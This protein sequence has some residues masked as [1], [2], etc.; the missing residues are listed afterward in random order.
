[1]I[2]ALESLQ[3]ELGFAFTVIDVDADPALVARWDEAVPV[4]ATAGGTEICRHVL[5]RRRLE[6][7]LCARPSNGPNLLR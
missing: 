5:D 1:M 4:L 7:A 3:P 6:S 2:A